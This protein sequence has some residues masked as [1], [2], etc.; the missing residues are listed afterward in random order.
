M[1]LVTTKHNTKVQICCQQ[2]PNVTQDFKD[3]CVFVC[4]S[5][6]VC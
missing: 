6:C 2:L 4:V 1:S 5:V 3:V